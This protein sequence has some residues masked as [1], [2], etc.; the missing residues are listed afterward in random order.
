MAQG[1]LKN[2][3]ENLKDSIAPKTVVVGN[4]CETY[5]AIWTKKTTDYTFGSP[6]ST[7]FQSSLK[8]EEVTS[9][10]GN[11]SVGYSLYD[12]DGDG[13]YEL[14]SDQT[15]R[16][17]SSYKVNLGLRSDGK[18]VFYNL[19]EDVTYRITM[20][21]KVDALQDGVAKIGVGRCL[22]NGFG[23]C[24]MTGDDK[25]DYNEFYT[26]VAVTDGYITVTK[27]YTCKGIFDISLNGTTGS[28]GSVSYYKDALFVTIGQGRVYVKSIT[29]EAVSYDHQLTKVTENGKILVDYGNKTVEVIP[30]N[31]YMLKPGSLKMNYTRHFFD[32]EKYGG[33]YDHT[34]PEHVEAVTELDGYSQSIFKLYETKFGKNS[35]SFVNPYAYSPDGMFISAE[36]V[37]IT[38]VSAGIIASS[39]RYEKTDGSKY[40][41]AG[42]RFRARVVD[43]SRI[44]E[45]GFIV[46][47]TELKKSLDEL[48]F[49]QDGS[50]NCVNA[51]KAVAFSKGVNKQYEK[52]NG[53][54]DYQV[55]IKDLTD[56][57]GRVDMTDVDFTVVV[58][59]KYDDN[60]SQSIAYSEEFS[61]S[62]KSVNMKYEK[63]K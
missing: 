26:A 52:G 63:L 9:S 58:Y 22:Q 59:A 13:N 23:I 49:N 15:S 18:D 2:S 3:K 54:T 30:D 40:Q 5:Y 17:P 19:R 6:N 53:Y 61:A 55:L 41:S 38:E 7:V 14:K 21:F 20:K 1:T 27:E 31:G 51:I 24:K 8:T 50:I 28:S 44:T 34:K 62:W 45:V 43:D 4:G 57:N 37:P 46:V 32:S 48:H 16:D 42:L 60:G 10:G 11:V 33:Q 25:Y 39:I 56:K 36:F 47:P 12:E 29:V 35:Y